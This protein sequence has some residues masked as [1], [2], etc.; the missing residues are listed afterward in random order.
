[1]NFAGRNEIDSRPISDLVSKFLRAGDKLAL[2]WRRLSE[3]TASPLIFDN[4]DSEKP[5]P[6]QRQCR[7]QSRCDQN[8]RMPPAVNRNW[9]AGAGKSMEQKQHEAQ[10][11]QNRVNAKVVIFC[12]IMLYGV[13]TRLA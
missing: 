8:E 12:E 2:T 5:P 7:D 9:N 10:I 11:R 13:T 6:A 4:W 1:L 3:G